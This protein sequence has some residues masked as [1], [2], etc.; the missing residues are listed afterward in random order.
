M[1]S[2]R[3]LE[4]RERYR[5]RCGYCG[6]TEQQSGGL[7]TVDH[8]RPRAQGGSDDGDNLVYCCHPCNEFKGHQ[9]SDALESR[10]L[11]PL[12]DDVSVH[13]IERVDNVMVPLTERGGLHIELLHLNRAELVANRR[14]RLREAIEQER[15]ADQRRASEAIVAEL[16]RLSEQIAILTG[17]IGVGGAETGPSVQQ[18]FSESPPA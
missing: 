1:R 5:A 7:L 18:T 13:I 6:V 9:W 12:L 2:D 4:V 14:N 3:R 11:H 8:F 16:R 10:P 17:G 15:L